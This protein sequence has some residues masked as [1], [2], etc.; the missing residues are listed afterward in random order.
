MTLSVRK[1]AMPLRTL[2]IKAKGILKNRNFIFL[3]SLFLGIAWGNYAHFLRE[4][5]IPV[6]ALIMTLSTMTVPS[7]AFRSIKSM[8]RPALTGTFLCYAF[9]GGLLLLLS[10]LLIRNPSF[11][12]GFVLIAA[13]P[14]AVAVIPFSVFLK[15]DTKSALFG[16][17]GAYLAGLFLTPL[18]LLIFLGTA[19]IDPSKVLIILLEL[20]IVPLVLSRVLIRTGLSR[21][22]EPV[23]GSILNWSFFLVVYVI[24]GL[25]SHVIL[26]RPLDLLP[27]I[28]MCFISTFVFGWLIE[29]LGR[30]LK[31]DKSLTMSMILLGTYK[32]WGLAG[33]LSLV[34]F[35]TES[36]VP[37]T[38]ASA[39]GIL[40]IVH[41][42]TRVQKLN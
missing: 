6:L 40:Y 26:G 17:I 16:S 22:I 4:T 28:F 36:A 27:S 25:N 20:I 19:F 41:L 29:I 15:A 5:V 35:S 34:F 18:M 7:G 30:I 12:T 3:L 1:K 31:L 38:V 32:N 10:S 13:V 37:A 33:G 21:L 39:F 14:P 23:R 24:T 42:Q 11:W 9:H 2:W 8:V